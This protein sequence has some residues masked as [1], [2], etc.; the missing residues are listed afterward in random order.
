MSEEVQLLTPQKLAKL[1]FQ[2]TLHLDGGSRFSQ[3]TLAEDEFGLSVVSVTDGSPSHNL[4]QSV[5][6]ATFEDEEIELDLLGKDQRTLRKA[7]CNRYNRLRFGDK[8]EASH[9]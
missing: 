7:F 4:T 6:I 8:G 9:D 2:K 5:C 3:T 1:K